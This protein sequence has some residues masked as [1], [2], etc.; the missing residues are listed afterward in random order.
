[1]TENEIKI[2]GAIFCHKNVPNRMGRR[3]VFFVRMMTS[4]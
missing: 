2:C 1:M 4:L 3:Q